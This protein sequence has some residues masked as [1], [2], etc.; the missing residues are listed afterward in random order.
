MCDIAGCTYMTDTQY[1]YTNVTASVVSLA[2]WLA[3]LTPQARFAHAA[4]GSLRSQRYCRL[5][6]LACWLACSIVPLARS[7][8]L[9]LTRNAHMLARFAQ[10]AGSRRGLAP[11]SSLVSFAR[12]AGSLRSQLAR[13]AGSWLALLAASSQR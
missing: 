3:S 8:A 6:S 11:L 4:A 2:C 9:L 13:F 12:F 7:H 5:A 10:A 1:K